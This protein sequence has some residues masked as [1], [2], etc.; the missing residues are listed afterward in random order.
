M[1]SVAF[2]VSA[3]CSWIIVPNPAW[4]STECT[5]ATRRASQIVLAPEPHS[6]TRTC[7]VVAANHASTSS[8]ASYVHHGT[9][10]LEIPIESWA[11]VRL[12]AQCRNR[13]VAW[14]R[15][16]VEDADLREQRPVPWAPVA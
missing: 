14:R 11:R 10:S 16:L 9:S 2:G 6:N 7:A 8:I 4:C 13:C 15:V 3:S 5:S 1:S 12:Y